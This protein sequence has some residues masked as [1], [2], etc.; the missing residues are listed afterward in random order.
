LAFEFQVSFFST[1]Y[2]IYLYFILFILLLQERHHYVNL[3]W[4]Y[5]PLDLIQSRDSEK[6]K[7]VKEKGITLIVVPCWWDGKEE[8]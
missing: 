8:R 6:L 2:F 4:H 1:C 7:L 3:D 5:K